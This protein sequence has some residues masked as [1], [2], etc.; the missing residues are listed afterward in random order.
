MEHDVVMTP[1]PLEQVYADPAEVVR[2]ECA[3]LCGAKLTQSGLMKVLLHLL[4]RSK[5]ITAAICKDSTHQS[6]AYWDI[7]KQRYLLLAHDNI[8]RSIDEIVKLCFCKHDSIKRWFLEL[9][10]YNLCIAL[11]NMERFLD[12]KTIKNEVDLIYWRAGQVLALVVNTIDMIQTHALLNNK[13][14][15]GAASALAVKTTGILEVINRSVNLL[16][17]ENGTSHTLLLRT[18]AELHM[19]NRLVI[20]SAFYEQKP[21]QNYIIH[22][23]I[24]QRL[25]ALRIQ[26]LLLL[27]TSTIDRKSCKKNEISRKIVYSMI[28]YYKRVA[29]YALGCFFPTQACHEGSPLAFC[30]MRDL[31]LALE[32]HTLL[33]EI[34]DSC[35]T[36][37]LVVPRSMLKKM[38]YV[39]NGINDAIAAYYGQLLLQ[40]FRACSPTTKYAGYY[41]CLDCIESAKQRVEIVRSKIAS[42]GSAVDKRL[43]MLAESLEESEELCALALR[44][45]E[46]PSADGYPSSELVSDILVLN[47]FNANEL[48]LRYS[49]YEEMWLQG[50]EI[51]RSR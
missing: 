47:C 25:W 4:T 9:C 21:A 20:N 50:G 35:S 22:D 12:H 24:E 44:D 11:S 27:A 42:C 23:I 31:S 38:L 36:G 28:L 1:S 10:L 39:C 45:R 26:L 5:I 51:G 7:A 2:G 48:P 34:K 3:T 49:I 14:V 18:T 19:L 16:Q 40:S 29:F 6:V 46:I 17:F 32:T 33:S 8:S 30:L 13:D 43:Q 15:Y 37:N 41:T